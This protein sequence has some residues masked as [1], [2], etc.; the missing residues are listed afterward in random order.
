MIITFSEFIGY[1]Y[2]SKK[3]YWL[4]IYLLHLTKIRMIVSTIPSCLFTLLL[5]LGGGS[6]T[7]DGT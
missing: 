3:Y 1:F 5:S 4:S 2:N 6:G 7:G